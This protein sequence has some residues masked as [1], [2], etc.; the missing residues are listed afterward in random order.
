MCVS[1]KDKGTVID[2]QSLN[3]SHSWVGC[4]GRI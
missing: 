4:G 3:V 2:E 1:A